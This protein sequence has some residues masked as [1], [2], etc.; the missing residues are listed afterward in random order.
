MKQKIVDF[1]PRTIAREGGGGGCTGTTDLSVTGTQFLIKEYF[2][3]ITYRKNKLY[4][5]KRLQESSVRI[6]ILTKSQLSW[7][8]PA[9]VI[10]LCCA[11]G[12][13]L[14][15][16]MT[17]AGM[18]RC[19]AVLDNAVAPPRI[20]LSKLRRFELINLFSSSS[21]RLDKISPSSWN[22]SNVNEGGILN[23]KY[24]DYFYFTTGLSVSIIYVS[25]DIVVINFLMIRLHL[26]KSTQ[27]V[28]AWYSGFLILRLQGSWWIVW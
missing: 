1:V 18:L 3:E 22:I 5:N 26:C 9:A 24:I 17:L 13:G 21:I 20:K 23:R 11:L 25:D 28:P 8:F 6:N 12:G 19:E 10:Y 4:T 15:G 16:K 27:L 2:N 14:A 7:A